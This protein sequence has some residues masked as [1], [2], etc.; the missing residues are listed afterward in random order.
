MTKKRSAYT[1]KRLLEALDYIDLKFVA[2]VT[3]K[4]KVLSVP[5]EYSPN[6]RRLY[7]AYAVAIAGAA[8]VL[9]LGG[10]IAAVPQMLYNLNISLPGWLQGIRE[11]E[12]Y[13]NYVPTQEEVDKLNEIWKSIPVD[14]VPLY[15]I[16]ETVD[17]VIESDYYYGKYGDCIIALYY[18]GL[19][20]SIYD[21]MYFIESYRF[22][23]SGRIMA[24]NGDEYCNLG[25]AFEKNWLTVED[26]A[27]LNKIIGEKYS[28]ENTRIVTEEEWFCSTSYPVNLPFETISEI[29]KSKYPEWYKDNCITNVRCFGQYG[30]AYAVIIDDFGPGEYQIEK[31]PV[32]INGVLFEYIGRREMLR[33]R[34]MSADLVPGIFFH[35]EELEIYK[36]GVFYNL[37]DAVKE[38]IIS[39]SALE[40]LAD[41][42]NTKSELFPGK[43]R[44]FDT[45]RPYHYQSRFAVPNTL[46]ISIAPFAC[47]KEYTVE[48]FAEL[49]CIG[50]K[51]DTENIGIGRNELGKTYILTFKDSSPQE[52]SEIASKLFLKGEIYYVNT[53]RVKD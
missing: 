19:G 3:D 25:E 14:G 1:D 42:Y 21:E 53:L 33:P 47:D 10:L 5:G 36:D 4:Y 51:I 16:G 7:K 48:D 29:I 8:C 35:Q 11:N 24:L 37:E 6:K 13:E 30:N 22:K 52:M 46:I 17:E 39:Q 18:T 45:K 50:I 40:D 31:I 15:D 12:M 38:N 41:S 27:R 32:E 23:P 43:M 26:V 34:E 49:G 9:L 2:E 20:G 28:T 44:S